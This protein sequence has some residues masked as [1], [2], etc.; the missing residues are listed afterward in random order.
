MKLKLYPPQAVFELGRRSNQEDCIYPAF[1]EASI[2]DR[3]FILCDGMGGHERGEIASGTVCR[4]LSDYFK[5]HIQSDE[6]LTDMQLQEALEYAYKRLDMVDNGEFRKAGTTLT[7]LYFHRGGCTA[8]HIGDSRIYHFR[9]ASKTILYKSR[10]HSLVFELY[11]AGEITY[12][13]MKTH[14]RKNQVSRAMIAGEDN[15]Q[16]MDVVHITNILPDDYFILCSDGILENLD[17]KDFME[18]LTV[19][20]DDVQKRQRLLNLTR[21]STDNHSAYLIH[22]LDVQKEDNDDSL[23]DDEQQVRFNAIHI[24]PISQIEQEDIKIVKEEKRTET[25]RHSSCIIS[26]HLN[27]YKLW[28]LLCIF[29]GLLAILF[30]LIY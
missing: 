11:Q 12:N 22:I 3:L 6:V 9:P 10:D 27:R 8:A 2:D 19:H 29:C 20:A 18:L 14:P 30:S 16:R 26:G 5:A 25:K 24:H 4:G 17:D 15:R 7:L 23:I 21:E 28:W 1:G 13:E